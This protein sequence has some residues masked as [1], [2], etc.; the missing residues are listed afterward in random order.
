[1]T[2]PV[3]RNR[4]AFTCAANAYKIPPKPGLGS[5]VVMEPLPG[6]SGTLEAFADFKKREIQPNS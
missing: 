4:I 5:Q 2:E 6:R 3:V 1:M